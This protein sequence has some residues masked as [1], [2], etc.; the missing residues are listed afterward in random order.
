ML[1]VLDDS[2]DIGVYDEG[3]KNDETIEQEKVIYKRPAFI[4]DHP[5]NTYITVEKALEYC[6]DNSTYSKRCL[7]LLILLFMLNSFVTM[8]WPLYFDGNEYKCKNSS[9]EYVP[10]D[11]KTACKNE[12]KGDIQIVGTRTLT[13]EF[14]L[15]CNNGS[16]LL[17]V[18]A[19]IPFANSLYFFGMIMSGLSIS[20]L[21][22]WKGRRPLLLISMLISTVSMCLM[23]VAPNILV[24]CVLF[25][26]SGFGF[27]AQEVLSLVYSS[28]ISGKRFRNHSMVILMVVWG[29]S[30]VLLGFLFNFIS[31]WRYIFVFVIG[32]PCGLSLIIAYFF[33]D[34]T[35]RYLVSRMKFDV[36]R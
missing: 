17:P 8:G 6:G 2:H 27:A 12:D 3:H 34:E 32:V 13:Y 11:I 20:I 15:I 23:G 9:G 16:I 25:F 18:A 36:Y 14:H 19:W 24:C 30:Q 35:P 26:F 1:N 29:A 31:Y 22:D 10:C 7:Y 33:L 4:V 21:S 28:E 5:E